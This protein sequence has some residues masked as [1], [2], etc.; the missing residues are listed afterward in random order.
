MVFIRDAAYVVRIKI[1]SLGELSWRSSF[2]TVMLWEF[3]SALTPT[4]IGG[5][6]FAVLILKREGMNLGSSVATIL[7]TALMD[8]LFYVLAVPTLLLL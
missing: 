7:I 1:L 6:A 4:V 5:S 8:E 3:A 2:N